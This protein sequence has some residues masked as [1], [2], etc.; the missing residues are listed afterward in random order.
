M[1]LSDAVTLIYP[2]YVNTMRRLTRMNPALLAGQSV[3]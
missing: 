1:L 3:V 2:E